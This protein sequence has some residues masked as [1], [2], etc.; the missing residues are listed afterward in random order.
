M[1]NEKTHGI[2]ESMVIGHFNVIDVIGRGGHGSQLD[3]GLADI[4]PIGDRVD[5]VFVLLLVEPDRKP[6]PQRIQQEA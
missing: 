5:L 4:L 1:Q 2:H 3:S 6:F